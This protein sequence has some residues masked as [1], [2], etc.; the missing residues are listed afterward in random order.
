MDGQPQYDYG[1][2]G[3]DKFFNRSIDSN[4]QQNLD[5]PGPVSTINRYEDQQNTGQYGDKLRVGNILI[6]GQ[7]GRLSLIENKQVILDLGEL[8]KGPGLGLH[9]ESN[10]RLLFG[11]DYKGKIKGKLS[12]TGYDADEAP[13]DKLI[14]SSDFNNF[15]IVSVLPYAYTVTATDATNQY[16]DF[17]IPHGLGFAP[18]VVGSFNTTADNKRRQ[19]PYFFQVQ[20]QSYYGTNAPGGTDHIASATVSVFSIDE[21]NINV[22]IRIHDINGLSWLLSAAVFTFKLYLLQE[23]IVS[24]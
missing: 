11:T 17:A 13:D 7:T 10:L 22:S 6:D 2:A 14:W 19:L 15:K 23:T 9:D 4:P 3:F 16:A 20:G 24:A 1:T 12:Q 5:T 8:E 18:T 21:V